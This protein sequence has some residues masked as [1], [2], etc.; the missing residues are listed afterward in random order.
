[1]S[2]RIL[3]LCLGLAALCIIVMSLPG[4]S[5]KQSLGNTAPAQIDEK[6]CALEARV[7]QASTK[8]G[9]RQ[10][11]LSYMQEVQEPQNSDDADGPEVKVFV[12]GGG[13]WLGVE[14]REVTPEN[15]KQLRL[16]AERG[17]L[18]GKIVPG[19]PAAKAGLKESDVITEVNGQRIEG[20][21]QFRRMIREIP[22]GRIVQLTVLRDG[23]S[24]SISLTLAK[25]ESNHMPGPLLRGG[26]PGSFAFQLPEIPDVES[27]G[28]LNVLSDFAPAQPRIGIDAEDLRGAFGNYFGAPNGEGVLIRNVFS[29]T[30]AEKAGLRAGD[31]IVGIDGNPTR[32]VRELR[33]QVKSAKAESKSF[34]VSLLRNKAELSLTL[35]LPAPVNKESHQHGERTTL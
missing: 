26:S 19:S 6:L 15:V 8:I 27:M 21:A 28:E 22:A 1:M 18:V 31:V 34:K 12:G 17:A 29:G 30:P 3:W 23:R 13:S 14:T 33:E 16:P 9:S 32:S 20:T 11:L 25:V 2:K 10:E 5:Q 7:Q 35:E 24:Q 4:F